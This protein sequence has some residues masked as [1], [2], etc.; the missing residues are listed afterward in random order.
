MNKNNKILLGIILVISMMI[1]V[2]CTNNINE[3]GVEDKAIKDE[4]IE[5]EEEEKINQNTDN[6]DNESR[7]IIEKYEILQGDNISYFVLIKGDAQINDFNNTYYKNYS[8][9]ILDGNSKL[10]QNIELENIKILAGIDFIDVNLDGYL[11]I[12]INTGGTWNETHELYNWDPLSNNFMKVKFEGFDMLAWF[13]VHD[14]YIDNFI[15]GNTPEESVKEKLVW[16][17]NN[18]IKESDY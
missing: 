11:D 16:N 4:I 8:I 9:D 13:E 10:L 5:K 14:G 12:V 3:Q 17:G 7:G 1:L 2:A 15:R 6:I 18:L